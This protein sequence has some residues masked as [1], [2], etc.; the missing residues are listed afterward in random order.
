MDDAAECL[1]AIFQTL[2]QIYLDDKV[3]KEKSVNVDGSEKCGPC[4]AHLVY[5]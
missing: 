3:L 2:H 4:V 5:G 1:E